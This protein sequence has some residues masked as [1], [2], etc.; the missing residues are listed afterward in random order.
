MIFSGT[1]TRLCTFRCVVLQEGLN[2]CIATQQGWRVSDA[3]KEPNCAFTLYCCTA[4]QCC[5]VTLYCCTACT[6]FRCCYVAPLCCCVVAMLR[7][8]DALLRYRA[9]LHRCATVSAAPGSGVAGNFSA[10]ANSIFKCKWELF[11]N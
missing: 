4:L 9:L 2:R 7:C 6:V 3:L 10:V 5:V 11:G 8:A 1:I